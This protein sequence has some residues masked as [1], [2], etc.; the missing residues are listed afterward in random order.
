M[1][2][3]TA[4]RISMLHSEANIISVDRVPSNNSGH[5][6]LYSFTVLIILI[7][8]VVLSSPLLSYLPEES[9]D[10][11]YYSNELIYL[12]LRN[13]KFGK[14]IFWISILGS[15]FTIFLLNLAVRKNNSK[16]QL[17][18]SILYTILS[19]ISLLLL[20]QNFEIYADKAQFMNLS[21]GGFFI[22][23]AI[24]TGIIFSI[25]SYRTYKDSIY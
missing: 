16:L 2:E 9:L 12:S 3:S 5:N 13:I 15:L 20:L 11:Q 8:V 23:I 6:V 19:T 25:I 18:G 7:A 17:Y 24:V 4:K 10:T 21:I 22:V 14:I 1:I